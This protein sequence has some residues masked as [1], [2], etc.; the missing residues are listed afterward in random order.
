MAQVDLSGSMFVAAGVCTVLAIR[1]HGVLLV[2]FLNSSR[3]ARI[4]LCFVLLH[5]WGLYGGL[6]S[7]GRY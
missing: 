3:L 2:C 6:E 1:V 7:G 5:I 4:D